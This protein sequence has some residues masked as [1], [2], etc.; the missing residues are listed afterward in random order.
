MP[1]NED[2]SDNVRIEGGHE[3]VKAAKKAIEVIV[4][5]LENTKVSNK[6]RKYR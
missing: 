6:K 4:L 2:T 1:D 3:N 5:K